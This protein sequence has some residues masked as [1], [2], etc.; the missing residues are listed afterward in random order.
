[1]SV[2]PCVLVRPARTHVYSWHTK[3]L[4]DLAHPCLPLSVCALDGVRVVCDLHSTERCRSPV[5]PVQN[6]NPWVR[7]SDSLTGVWRTTRNFTPQ[8]KRTSGLVSRPGY[9]GPFRVDRV[10]EGSGLYQSPTPSHQLNLFLVFWLSSDRRVQN[11]R[12]LTR[13]KRVKIGVAGVKLLH[14]GYSNT[15]PHLQTQG[16]FKCDFAVGVTVSC[17][18]SPPVIRPF[19]DGSGYLITVIYVPALP[20]QA[21]KRGKTVHSCVVARGG[22]LCRRSVVASSVLGDRGLSSDVTEPE[23]EGPKVLT[24]FM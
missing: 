18:G 17:L 15:I 7:G 20:T 3:S 21:R 9:G 6:H 22:L 19:R 5:F 2:D 10:D 23:R 14:E 11:P 16:G 8:V 13:R 12:W 24:H 4:S 1:M